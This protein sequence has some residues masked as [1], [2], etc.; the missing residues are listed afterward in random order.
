MKQELGAFSNQGMLTHPI[1]EKPRLKPLGGLDRRAVL[2][3]KWPDLQK[4]PGTY[5]E[6]LTNM[7]IAIIKDAYPEDKLT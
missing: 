5:K 2:L 4:G 3:Q 7:K 6:A 1:R